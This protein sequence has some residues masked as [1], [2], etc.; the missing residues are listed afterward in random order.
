VIAVNLDGPADKA[1]VQAAI[2]AAG[3]TMPVWS[4]ASNAFEAA[5]HAGAL[6]GAVLIARNGLVA[7]TWTN[8]TDPMRHDVL[9]AV[10]QTLQY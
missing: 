2:D 8:L 5:F 1:R 10:E 3:L 9:W 7:M 6:P 4:D